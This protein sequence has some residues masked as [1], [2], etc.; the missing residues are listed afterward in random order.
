V[1]GAPKIPAVLPSARDTGHAA[2]QAL[3]RLELELEAAAVRV[4]ELCAGVPP[5]GSIAAGGIDV[6]CSLTGS[7]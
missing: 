4:E 6:A 3:V 1:S 5:G 7:A 2:Q